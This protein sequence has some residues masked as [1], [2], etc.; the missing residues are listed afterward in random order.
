MP[1]KINQPCMFCDVYPCVCEGTKVKKAVRSKPKQSVPV[2]PAPVTVDL[3][4]AMK[5][6]VSQKTVPHLERDNLTEDQETQDCIKILHT[7]LHEDEIK[8]RPYLNTP[9][10]RAERW[11]SRN[12]NRNS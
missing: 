1:R 12:A 3:K 10:M 8:R 4:A 9:E 11:R 5:A 2:A 7:I 6:A